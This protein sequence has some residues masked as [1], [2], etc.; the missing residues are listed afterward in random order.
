MKLRFFEIA[1]KASKNSNHHSHVIGSVIVSNGK[2]V[3]TGYNQIKTHPDSPHPFKHIHAEFKAVLAANRANLSGASIYVYKEDK[4]GYIS[5]CKPCS[6]CER[7]LRSVG[8][9]RVYYTDYKKYVYN[10]YV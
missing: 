3:S 5:M 8:I 1:K 2:V 4:N 9:K 6:S 10:K 7:F